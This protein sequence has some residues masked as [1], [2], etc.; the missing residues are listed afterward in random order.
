[1]IER[2]EKALDKK[3]YVGAVLSD[4]FKAFACINHK[5]LIA[6]LEAYG[7][8]NDA[9]N[10]VYDYLSKRQQRAKVNSSYS[11]WRETKYGVHQGSIYGHLLFNTFLNDNSFHGKN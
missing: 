10:F 7:I 2:W 11:S 3:K 9:L 8:G 1:M 5:L 6:K 4:L